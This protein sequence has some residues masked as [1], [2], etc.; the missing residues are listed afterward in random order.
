MSNISNISVQT[1]QIPLDPGDAVQQTDQNQPSQPNLTVSVSMDVGRADGTSKT[2][3]LEF[4][5]VGLGDVDLTELEQ[6]L[7]SQLGML[8]NAPWEALNQAAASKMMLEGVDNIAQALSQGGVTF[9]EENKQALVETFSALERQATATVGYFAEL[10]N[11]GNYPDHTEFLKLLLET[12]QELREMSSIA[13]QAAVEGEF[14]LVLEQ[15]ANMRTAAEL[16]Y[17]SGKSQITAD[18]IAA[19][20]QIGGAAF[21]AL[22]GA[23]GGQAVGMAASQ[24]GSGIGTVAA[25]HSKINSLDYKKAADL[26]RAGNKALEAAQKMSQASQET[27]GE[28]KDLGKALQDFVLRMIQDF[29]SQQYQ[30]TQRANI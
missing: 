9:A 25:S 17:D 27:A 1:N 7:E 15:A 13:K 18:N 8:S 2:I 14:E 26:L 11:S 5:M 22:A 23:A 30:V 10:M 19:G 20:F 4:P 29:N 3:S 12:A 16:D 21:G 24:L 6:L 28:L